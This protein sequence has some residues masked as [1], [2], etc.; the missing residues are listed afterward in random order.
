MNRIDKKFR[1]LEKKNQGA[2]IAFVTA[3]DPSIRDTPK[4]VDA[5]IKGGVDLLELGLPFSDPIADGPT[6]QKASQRSLENGM[7][8]DKYFSLV[9][10]LDEKSG[11]PKICMTYYNLVLQ[12]GLEKFARDCA[13]TGID[14]LIVSDLPPEESENLHEACRKNNIHLIF[15]VA[16][17]TTSDRLKKISKKSRGF[18][19]VVS[20]FGVTG[21]REK[22]SSSIKPLL[23]KIKRT[24]KKVT[25]KKR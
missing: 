10:K 12:R 17:T 3:G 1:E 22:L 16:P 13:D 19:Y 20:L 11:I 7:N 21:A 5:L 18:I 4:V 2:L 9:K 24:S 8:T 14:G 23:K 15:L 25:R 6:I